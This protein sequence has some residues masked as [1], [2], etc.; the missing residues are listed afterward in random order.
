MSFWEVLKVRAGT[1]FGALLV[2]AFLLGA[3]VLVEASWLVL[4]AAVGLGV[5]LAAAVFLLRR[6]LR[7]RPP[8]PG[9]G[10]FLRTA[11]VTTALVVGLVALPIYWLAVKVAVDPLVLP[12]ATLSDG[13]KTVVFQGMVHI[14]SEGFY[15]SVVYD[16]EAALA[17]GFVIFYEGIRPGD[18]ASDAWFA[19]ALAGGRDLSD[20]Y[21]TLADICGLK[22]QLDYFALL[23]PEMV[24]HPDRHVIADVTT[25]EMKAE[26]DRLQ[27]TRPGEE[28]E[29]EAADDDGLPVE[30]MVEWLASL[31][32]RQRNLVGTVCRGIFTEVLGREDA[33]AGTDEMMEEIVLGYRNRKLAERIAAHPAEKI[34][35]TYGAGHLSGVLADLRAI[36]PAWELKSVSWARAI[37]APE[38]LEGRI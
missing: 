17:E 36:D 11:L 27:A 2:L 24:A 6:L 32:S 31:D 37:A 38:E 15:K 34:Y 12:R 35:V 7:R 22:F 14:G 29:A 13:R 3:P 8:R 16:L 9:A 20:N 30:A 28:A 19:E 23:A 4:A 26:W 1:L 33:E 21:K 18:A 10:S 5:I 25:A